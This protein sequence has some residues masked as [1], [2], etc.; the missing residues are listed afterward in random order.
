MNSF[1]FYD[2]LVQNFEGFV[3]N[4]CKLVDPVF[5]D[6]KQK[7]LNESD[8]GNWYN[9][10]YPK[11][12]YVEHLLKTDHFEKKYFGGLSVSELE[13]ITHAATQNEIKSIIFDWDRTL[14]V[15]EGFLNVQFLL[16]EWNMELDTFFQH[17]IPYLLGGTKRN[18]AI[19]SMFMALSESVPHVFI[20]T[21]NPEPTMSEMVK[22]LLKYLKT[23]DNFQPV[24]IQKNRYSNQS[25]ATMLQIHIRTQSSMPLED[26]NELT[27]G[28]FGRPYVDFSKNN[29]PSPTLFPSSS[30]SSSSSSRYRSTKKGGRILRKNKQSKKIRRKYTQKKYT[31]S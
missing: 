30:S 14:S 24:F 5:M 21:N 9:K 16:K 20:I 1:L 12:L 22:F 8:Y 10:K 3:P 28:F 7:F 2:D 17:L 15:C 25:K 31:H 29:H 13:K 19:K 18:Q 6:G 4:A 11:N 23:P 27:E 26:K